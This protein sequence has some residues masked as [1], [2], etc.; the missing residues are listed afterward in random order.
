MLEQRLRSADERRGTL[1][2]SFCVSLRSSAV[3]AFGF[4]ILAAGILFAADPCAPLSSATATDHFRSGEC[5]AAKEQWK[6]AEEQ[7]A[8]CRRA[9]PRS[10][11][12][13]LG[14]ANALIRLNQ[15]F[16]AAIELSELL[17]SSPNSVRGLKLYA[18]LLAS[19]LENESRAELVLE[20]CLKLAP[21]DPEAWRAMGE[22]YFG[23]RR[24][25]DAIRYLE[26]SL[27]LA[28]RDPLTVADLARCHGQASE[29]A[30][31]AGMFARA[32]QMNARA[33][34]PEARVY[35]LYA[36]HLLDQGQALDSVPYFTRALAIARSSDA[37]TGRAR[38]YE[39]LKDWRRA[40]SDAL[41]AVRKSPKRM[42]AHLLLVRVYKALNDEP[43]AAL[44][45]DRVRKVNEEQRELQSAKRRSREALRLYFEQVQPLLRDQKF[46]EA[47]PPGLQVAELWP[48]FPSPYFVL[49][50]CYGQT[51]RP[52]QAVTY[53]NKYLS[54][55]PNSADG[56]AALGVLLL[57]QDRKEDALRELEQAISL[58][59][60]MLE[61]RKAAASVH[62][63]AGN[64]PAAILALRGTN[65]PALDN[66]AQLLL[67]EALLNDHQS[68][69][70]LKQVD[71][72]LS[73]E[74]ANG[75]ARNL[76][77]RILSQ[78]K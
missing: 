20:R 7:F 9:D 3:G 73:S 71:A 31:A 25:A 56:H 34:K 10:E 69:A 63:S 53:F 42:D 44:Y 78:A 66:E 5:F 17:E 65:P 8:I 11:A 59:P 49:G 64:A 60:A 55:Q 62:L 2:S 45:I 70:A 14:H 24:T 12:A 29:N 26:T 48:S 57:Q 46:A 77:Q 1:I 58:D 72:V 76:K 19:A 30:K 37:Y 52:A 22:L 13:T 40:E 33:V 6:Q 74:P 27:K 36:E 47:I 18:G 51:G 50:V 15:P 75:A 67:G 21:S 16:D 38:A 39:Q 54:L 4:L 32:V 35:Q 41:A 23:Q 43:K 61:A 28:P 68:G